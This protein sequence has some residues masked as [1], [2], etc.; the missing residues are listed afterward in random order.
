MR[1]LSISQRERAVSLYYRHDLEKIGKRRFIVLEQLCANE[2]IVCS[3]RSLRKL[4][5]KWWKYRTVCNLPKSNN[6]AKITEE[7]LRRLNRA[8]YRNRSL[9]S[10][11]L[12]FSL[13]L[14]MSSRSIQRYLNILVWKKIR[15]K[16]CQVA[17]FKNRLERIAFANA[18]LTFQDKFMNSIFIDESSVQANQNAN[19]IWNKKFPDETRL[20]LLEKYSHLQSVH[21]IGGISRK[22][23]T[24]LVIFKSK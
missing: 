16:Y 21:A 18:A 24:P 2:D 12:K 8:V 23:P 19:K 4:M 6:L 20:G 10:R 5:G 13:N 11:K 17:S 9:T 14:R 15:S 7:E 1:R 22:G 3:A